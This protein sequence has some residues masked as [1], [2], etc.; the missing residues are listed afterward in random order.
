MAKLTFSGTTQQVLLALGSD[1]DSSTKIT[2]TDN[3]YT[4]AN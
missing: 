4:L 1:I 2:I 3:Q